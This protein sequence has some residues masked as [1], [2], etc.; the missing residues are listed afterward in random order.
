MKA[1]YT[2]L[3]SYLNHR[4]VFHNVPSVRSLEPNRFEIR[5]IKEKKISKLTLKEQGWRMTLVQNR[6]QWQAPVNTV[7]NLTVD[8]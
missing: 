8:Q 2:V 1:V 3:L 6:D 7:M 5:G 4:S